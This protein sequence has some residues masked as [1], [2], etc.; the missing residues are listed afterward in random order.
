MTLKHDLANLST[1]AR[2]SRAR[3]LIGSRVIRS[4]MGGFVIDYVNRAMCAS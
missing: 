2:K 1:R 4:W 3:H